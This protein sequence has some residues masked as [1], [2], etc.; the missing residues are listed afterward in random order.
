MMHLLRSLK[1]SLLLSVLEIDLCDISI[2]T[3]E[4]SSN[5]LQSRAFSLNVEEEDKGELD[6][7]PNLY[8]ISLFDHLGKS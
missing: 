3:I 4:D 6:S 5:L 2:I 7:N 8:S 1:D